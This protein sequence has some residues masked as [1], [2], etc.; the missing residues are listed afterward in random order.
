MRDRI[1]PTK[2][3]MEVPQ[4]GRNG[5]RFPGNN[6]RFPGNKWSNGPECGRGGAAA[7]NVGGEPPERGAAPFAACGAAGPVQERV[8]PGP[9][10]GRD[11]RRVGGAILRMPPSS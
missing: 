7:R 6:T 9:G 10:G 1:A 8:Y 2:A 4:P 3:V 11:H 5:T